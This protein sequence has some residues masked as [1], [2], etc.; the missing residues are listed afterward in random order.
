MDVIVCGVSNREFIYL[1]IRKMIQE[2]ITYLII[3]GAISYTLYSFIRFLIPSKNK[4]HVCSGGCSGCALSKS[5]SGAKMHFK[6]LI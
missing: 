2:I 4:K 1:K 6:E 3:F 5:N